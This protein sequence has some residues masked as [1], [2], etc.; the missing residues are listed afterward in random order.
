MSTRKL[1]ATWLALAA[2]AL[3]VVAGINAK[4]TG[5]SHSLEDHSA[6]LH[7]YMHDNYDSSMGAHG[8]EIEADALHSIAH[9]W[10]HG[11]ATDAELLAQ[12][13]TARVQFDDMESQL[14]AGGLLSGPNQDKEAKKIFQKIKKYMTLCE[15]YTASGSQ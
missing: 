1:T 10:D 8:M 9:D 13:A 7:T 3:P 12:V 6:D 5:A 11:T 4:I 14:Q 2:M 15:A